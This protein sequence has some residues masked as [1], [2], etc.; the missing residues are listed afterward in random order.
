VVAQVAVAVV[1]VSGAGLLIKS[2]WLLRQVD[3][4]F[5]VEQ[6]VAAEVPMPSF[7]GDSLVRARQYYDAVVERVRAIP[8]VRSAAA[9]SLVPF[10]GRSGTGPIETETHPT[11]AG[12]VPPTVEMAT[13]TPEYF[14]TMG[15]PLLAGRGFESTDREGSPNVVLVDAVAARAL[16][17]AEEAVGKRVRYVWRSDWMTVVGVTGAVKRD[18]L[19]VAERP[20]LYLPM[21]QALFPSTM[22]LVVRAEGD[23]ASLAP[24]L[25]AAVAAVDR[26][27]PVSHI[28]ALRELVS[29]SAARPRFTM[30]LLGV[31]ATVALLLGA[32]GIY[33]VIACAVAQRTREMGVR[34]ALGANGS[35][36]LTMVLRKGA[37]LAAVGAAIGLLGALAGSRLLAGMLYG[38]TPS[39][40]AVLVAVPVLLVGVALVASFVPA[41]RA[42][43]VDPLSAMRVE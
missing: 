40:P 2:F 23:A 36:V 18:G 28:R 42:A 39:D 13:V 14:R 11:P 8:R 15:I 25:R 41:W 9:A 26:N 17:P 7:S 37:T 12:G 29:A 33:G 5:R 20:S 4:G 30:T 16:W 6:V 24:S 32:V 35:D 34:M 38:V 10:G 19:G 43:H 3:P 27:V 21:Q 31:F 1:L 22:Q